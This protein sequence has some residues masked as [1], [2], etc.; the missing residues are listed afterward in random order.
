M[1]SFLTVIGSLTIV[2]MFGLIVGLDTGR[3]EK[4]P[5]QIPLSLSLVE[6]DQSYPAS[7]EK[8]NH[9]SDEYNNF[10][11]KLQKGIVDL[12]QWEKVKKAWKVLE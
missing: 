3:A 7:V 9:F 12:K 8:L 5:P 1:R 4:C 10:I 6:G 2:F 11:Q